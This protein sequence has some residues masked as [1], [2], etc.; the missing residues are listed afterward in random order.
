MLFVALV[1]KQQVAGQRLADFAGDEAAVVLYQRQRRNEVADIAARLHPAVA[2]GGLLR[3][4]FQL[5]R[6]A[7][8]AGDA[9]RMQPLRVMHGERFIDGKAHQ[10][11]AIAV[12]PA[13]RR[14]PFDLRVDDAQHP[15]LEGAALRL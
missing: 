14:P 11:G 13:R 15:G 10:A 12:R 3:I 7:P 6:Q 9:V 5:G 1:E 8:V 2:Q 4:Q